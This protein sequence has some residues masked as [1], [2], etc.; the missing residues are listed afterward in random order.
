VV[1]ANP[2]YS[3]IEHKI[4]SGK[5]RRAAEHAGA[6]MSFFPKDEFLYESMLTW[7]DEH[8]LSLPILKKKYGIWFEADTSNKDTQEIARQIIKQ[9]RKEMAA[10]R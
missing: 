10:A 3:F 7:K 5:A 1:H 2:P 6:V 8:E 9:F 4:R